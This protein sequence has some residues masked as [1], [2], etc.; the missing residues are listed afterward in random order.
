MRCFSCLFWSGD[1]EWSPGFGIFC[2]CGVVSYICGAGVVLDFVDCVVVWE[3]FGAVWGSGDAIGAL[4]G[5]MRVEVE[6]LGL[7]SVG[8]VYG[9]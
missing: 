8:K 9:V 3:W 2:N 6:C 4:C 1:W 5:E 7:I